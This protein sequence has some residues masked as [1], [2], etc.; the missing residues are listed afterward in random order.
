MIRKGGVVVFFLFFVLNIS[1]WAQEDDLRSTVDYKVDKMRTEL[2]LTF[3]QAEAIRPIIK[4]YLIKRSAVLQEVA[5]EGIVDHVSVKK[6]LKAL[7]ENEYQA[8]SKILSE[9]QMKEW[10]NKEMVMATLN[11]D[12]AESTVDDGSS[13]GA[14]GANF[15]F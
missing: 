1:L 4:D 6:T 5:G 7:K 10:I 14:D 2:K 8:L 9:D 3:S 15:K 11:P 13:L 12:S